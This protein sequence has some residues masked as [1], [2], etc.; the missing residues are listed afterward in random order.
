MTPATSAVQLRPF[1]P[2]DYP[3]LADLLT[4][5]HPEQP[6]DATALR[7]YDDGRAE[8]EHLARTLAVLDGRLVGVVTTEFARTHA[9]PG[10]YSLNLKVRPEW[11][12]SDLPERLY[13][14]GELDLAPL[15]PAWIVS[16]VREDWWERPVLEARGFTE[17]D[18]MW[19]S[20]LDLISFDPS[21]LEHR[22]A[23][24]AQA[25]VQVLPLSQ[26]GWGDEASERRLYALVISLLQDVPGATPITPWPFE[27]WR[28]RVVEAPDFT[29][30]GPLVAVAGG[31]WMGFTEL[32]KP[33]LA[34][35]GTVIQ[36]LT[37]V[38][39]PWRGHGVAWALKLAAARRAQANGF[40]VA[41]TMNHVVNREMLGI[42]AAMGFAKEPAW[43]TLSR[44]G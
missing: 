12:G 15:N 33:D 5:A 27:L 40:R 41:R 42:N 2:E 39:R 13:V 35:P 43:I 37:G 38:T 28:R 20:T 32:Y 19:G 11:Q 8:G 22:A 34:R 16:Q 14:Q 29:P 10:W 44:S 21:A 7:A 30:D 6:R 31:E 3:A 18:R 23:K 26:A 17:H 9:Q 36:G 25:G 1:A 4:A 24:A